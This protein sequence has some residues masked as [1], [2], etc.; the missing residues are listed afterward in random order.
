MGDYKTKEGQTEDTN[1]DHRHP[2]WLTSKVPLKDME[3]FGG[4]KSI[5]SL[6]EG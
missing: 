4:S 3:S 5:S 2:P 1:L 6:F